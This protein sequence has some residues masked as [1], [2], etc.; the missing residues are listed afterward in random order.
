MANWYPG[1]LTYKEFAQVNTFFA[2]VT[3]AINSQSVQIKS[4]IEANRAAIDDQTKQIVAS[5]SQIVSAL[6]KGFD[7]I[8]Q[9]NREGFGN[10]TSAIEALHSDL[11]FNFGI[12]IQRMEYQN[13]ILSG[14]LKTIQAPFET[15]VREY[16]SKACELANGGILDKAIEYFN[17]S[18]SLP[19]GDIFFPSYYQ[20][21]RL[22][23]TGVDGDTNIIDPKIASD[24]LL[25]ANKYGAGILRTNPAFKSILADCKFFLS[26]SFY[27]QLSGNKNDEIEKEL[28]KKALTF[29]EEA[30]TLNPQLS[31]GYYFLA[32][33]NAYNE[34][35]AEMME[36]L[37]KAIRL[38]RN[39]ALH[40]YQDEIFEPYAQEITGM[41][42][43]IR[44]SIAQN[45]KPELRKA[46]AYLESFQSKG[47]SQFP[48]LHAEFLNLEAEYKIAESEYNTGTYF[49]MDN[50]RLKLE[51]L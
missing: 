42:S 19:T 6:E 3:G 9:I 49:G 22:Y 27:F 24:L 1:V 26:Q 20:L 30:V 43:T 46:Q 18:L 4:S 17:K 7:H 41:L 29:A 33:Y 23:L 32:K 51:E 47:I 40:I 2:D 36:N 35:Q 25:T 48:H 21:G 28:V 38:D 39:Y 12:L 50:C 44:E 16:Y 14:I 5:N 11:N 34:K 45:V 8:A 15:Q 31:Q 37:S 10:V 13:K